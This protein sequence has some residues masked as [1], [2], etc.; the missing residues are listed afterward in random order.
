MLE[1]IARLLAMLI[2]VLGVL[3][4]IGAAFSVNVHADA[5]AYWLAAQRLREGL[6]LYSGPTGDETQIYRYAPWFAYAWLPL[7]YLSQSA[8]FTI[9]RAILLVASAAAVWPLV[10]RPT[11]ATATLALLVFGLL[12]SNLPAANVTALLVGA[13]AISLRT[14]AGPVVIGLAASF[15]L[16]PILFVAGYLAERRWR[17]AAVA[18]GV[19]A[20]LWLH[21]LAFDLSAY[22]TS[23][24]GS[25][26][27]LGGTSL[28]RLS[29]IVW[30]L[31]AVALGALLVA[32]IVRRSR[33]TWLAVGAVIPTV[34]PRVWIPDA[35]YVVV[36][37]PPVLEVSR[38]PDMSAGTG[39]GSRPGTPGTSPHR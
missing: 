2:A 38:S 12:V 9:W 32:L 14:R 30:G 16:F 11:P 29:P 25:S 34:V 15:K 21:L 5:D 31:A 18:T 17:A 7:T 4:L 24:G 28:Y 6:P 26:F 27:F 1:R 33:W 13:L 22:P 23:V 39:P 3:L 10:R 8:A 35:A 36:G 20:L 19:T 37:A